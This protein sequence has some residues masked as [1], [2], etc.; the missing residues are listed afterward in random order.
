MFT[1]LRVDIL[2]VHSFSAA[3]ISKWEDKIL[4]DAKYSLVN[5]LIPP[6][7]S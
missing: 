4:S 3:E 2:G 7:V 5:N 1:I 6:A